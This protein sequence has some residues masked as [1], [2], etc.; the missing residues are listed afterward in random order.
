MPAVRDD[1]RPPNPEQESHRRALTPHA[2]PS[3]A[4]ACRPSLSVGSEHL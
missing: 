2:C 4:V 1:A 3:S